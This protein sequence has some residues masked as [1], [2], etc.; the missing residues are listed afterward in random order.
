MK[1]GIRAPPAPV[2]PRQEALNSAPDLEAREPLA[3]APPQTLFGP[4]QEER[5]VHTA[6]R[7]FVAPALAAKQL[8]R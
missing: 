8:A 2:P 4:S 3:L 5:E 1:K 6:V 7:P